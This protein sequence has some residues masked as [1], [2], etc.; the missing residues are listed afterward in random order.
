M[1]SADVIDLY[2]ALQNFRVGVCKRTDSDC[3]ASYGLVSAPY[4]KSGRWTEI[5][6]K[7]S[8]GGAELR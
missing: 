8:A 1:T 3:V 2:A 4:R 7:K 5:D 6:R